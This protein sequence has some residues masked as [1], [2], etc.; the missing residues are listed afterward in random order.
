[1]KVMKKI[2]IVGGGFAGVR[3]ALDLAKKHLRDTKVVLISDR[4]HFEY[5]AALYRVVTGRSPLEVCI[6]LRDIF[7]KTDV[8]VVEDE[9]TAV[10]LQQK[11]LTGAS[12]SHYDFDFLV[13][14]LGS[15]TVYFGIPG[16]PEFSYGFKSITAALRL[17]RHLHELFSMDQKL[18]LETRVMEAQLVIVGGGASGTELA[19]EL[20][21]YTRKLSRLH[22]MPQSL[23]TI[24]LIEA[25]PRLLPL[26]PE[27]ISARVKDRLHA[28]GVNVFLNRVVV[29]E[30]AE[31][32][33]LKD[34]ELK[35]KTL[36]WTSG[37]KPNKLYQ[38]I[39]GL[40]FDKKGTVLVDHFLQPQGEWGHVWEN[41]F[42]VGDAAATPYTGMA[43]TAIGDGRFV[44]DTIAAT[45]R[46]AGRT[47]YDEKKPIYA[48]PIGEGWAA[49]LWGRWRFY[50]Y[51]GWI[52]RRALDL[53]FF[54]S[55]LPL[56][57]AI[58]AFRQGSRVSEMCP[59]CSRER[60]R[61]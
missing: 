15:E 59:M 55:I 43:Q 30:E 19:G 53:R 38:A 57:K 37:V 13:L 9:I 14:A 40:K 52:V 22:A 25:A 5:H 33:H 44:A 1:M 17:K 32:V 56:S 45:L 49:V 39:A 21:A 31:T 26:L 2:V 10:D 61:A 47:L 3:C 41:V 27:D 20:A 58:R 48:V 60:P 7:E 12:G 24:D 18:P 34:M 51:P 29:Q 36:I 11:E 42:V 46:G 8:D 4:P 6:L 54:F 28:L 16:L 50:G 35:S 23:V